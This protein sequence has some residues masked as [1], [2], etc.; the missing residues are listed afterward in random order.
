MLSNMEQHP[1]KLLDRVRDAIRLKHY[2]YRTEETYVHWI[3]RFI[4]FH[5]KQHPS[6]MGSP[7]IE[8]FLTHLAVEAHVASSTQNQA[9]RDLQRNKLPVILEV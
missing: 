8:L 4:L 6:E 2:S 9:L 5:N 3:R 1:R 7:E